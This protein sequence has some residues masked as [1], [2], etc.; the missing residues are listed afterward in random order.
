MRLE[1]QQYYA[2]A[3]KDV[4]Q[5]INALARERSSRRSNRFPR[6]RLV[7]LAAFPVDMLANLQQSASISAHLNSRCLAVQILRWLYF[8]GL[9]HI[10]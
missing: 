4:A 5:K 3:A 8:T 10:L 2:I 6:L 1:V 9:N 7:R